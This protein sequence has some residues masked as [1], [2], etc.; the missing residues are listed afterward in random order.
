MV[1][2]GK[3]ESVSPS[4][5]QEVNE[6]EVGDDLSTMVPL[7]WAEGVRMNSWRGGAAEGVEEADL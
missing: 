4:L 2:A 5:V 6:L 7:F 3:K 1:A